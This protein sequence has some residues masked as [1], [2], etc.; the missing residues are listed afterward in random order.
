MSPL[1]QWYPRLNSETPVAA[2]ISAAA[3]DGQS[4]CG[5]LFLLPICDAR[6]QKNSK[7]L[8]PVP[9]KQLRPIRF[10]GKAAKAHPVTSSRHAQNYL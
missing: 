8:S 4:P 1:Q 3:E 5:P 2:S 10:T 7:T 9:G 6:I